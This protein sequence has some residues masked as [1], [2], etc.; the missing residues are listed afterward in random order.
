M[1]IRLRTK[2]A[3]TYLVPVLSLF[4]VAGLL[5]HRAARR[6]LEDELGKRL[7]SI[8]H[9]VAAHYMAGRDA[10]R[11]ARLEPDPEDGVRTRARLNEQLESI[12][13]ELGL[14]RVFV[15]RSDLASLLDTDPAIIP[16]TPLFDVEA[17]RAELEGITR[18]GDAVNSVMFYDDSGTPFMNGYAPIYCEDELAGLVGTAGDAAFFQTLDS[19]QAVLIGLG[20]LV[21][22]LVLLVSVYASDRLTRPIGRLVDA[23]GLFGRGELHEAVEVT[24]S[25]EIGFLAGAFN[26]MKTSLD[27]R[28]EQMQ[29]M[30]SGIAH[31][32]RN[33][34][35]GMEL[36]C[37]LL[38]DELRDQPEQQEHVGK[39][40]RE[41][42]Y[43]SRV[44][45]DFLSFARRRPLSPERFSAT[46]MLSKVVDSLGNRLAA[47]QVSLTVAVS[48]AIE[49]TGEKE[50]LRG[51]LLNIAQ[52][53]VQAC[54]PGGEVAISIESD[55]NERTIEVR[56]NG[57]GIDPDKLDKI[58][59]PF[60]TTRQK[61]TGLGLALVY[62]TVQ[63]HGGEI[64]VDSEVGQGTR[65][66]ITLPFDSDLKP[67]IHE[68][69]Y[70]RS[71][72]G[73]EI[74]G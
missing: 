38:S 33:P 25:D 70:N 73:V 60:F 46:E 26:D 9:S 57:R 16:G 14:R 45:N 31:E 62:K 66:V 37:S 43:L 6:G 15:F 1:Q 18:G 59:E 30:L 34:L 68:P 61:G 10:C 50:A 67:L 17:D 47:A 32:V 23:I 72:G 27:R 71:T 48:E 39:I 5:A 56:D 53:A 64:D 44:V 35:A 29:L 54:E 3:V 58:F 24:T 41:L 21:V 63:E 22:M 69:D 20:A 2:L 7:A 13:S 19:F 36:F 65:F 40:S 51:V 55:G 11:V 74:I 42:D 12:R 49:L 8:S 4:L 28:D 52:N